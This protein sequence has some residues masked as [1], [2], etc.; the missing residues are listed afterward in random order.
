MASNLCGSVGVRSLQK[1][2]CSPSEKIRTGHCSGT[3]KGMPI[4]ARLPGTGTKSIAK[5]SE[6]F[7]TRNEQSHPPARHDLLAYVNPQRHRRQL[8]KGQ[9][10]LF[11]R[12]VWWHSRVRSAD[13]YVDPETHVLMRHRR[14]P[15]AV[16]RRVIDVALNS[17]DKCASDLLML[18]LLSRRSSMSTER[19]CCT[20][21][22]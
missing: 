9:A 22:V 8:E 10:R 17:A 20:R 18:K 4:I 1:S 5:S 6:L 19:S 21:D 11:R 13:I 15:R 16:S 3:D 2:G 14:R 7:P 12:Q